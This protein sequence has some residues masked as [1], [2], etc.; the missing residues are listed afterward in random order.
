MLIQ[1]A[2][3]YDDGL[4]L[5]IRNAGCPELVAEFYSSGIGKILKK[6]G[7]GRN[8]FTQDE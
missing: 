7:T 1:N 2:A 3:N 4:S 5:K 8:N 6:W